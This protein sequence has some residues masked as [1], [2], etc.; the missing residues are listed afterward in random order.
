MNTEPPLSD[1]RWSDRRILLEV[2]LVA[3][4]YAVLATGGELLLTGGEM[5]P[6]APGLAAL[7]IPAAF[8]FWALFG[9]HGGD[10]VFIFCVFLQWLVP[11]AFT[12][13]VVAMCRRWFKDL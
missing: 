8:L 3:V 13:L 5:D 11:G 10:V 2:V 6:D 1:A 9:D 12:G 4:A 7:N